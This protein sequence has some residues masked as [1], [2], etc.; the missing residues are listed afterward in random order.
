MK[1]K[2]SQ[3]GISLMFSIFILTFILSIALGG[4]SIVIRQVQITRNIGYSVISFCAAD[5]GV[6]KVL[7]KDRED[8]A[9]IPNG[10]QEV[11]MPLGNGA[12]YT[13]TVTKGGDTIIESKGRY[14]HTSRAIEI[15]Y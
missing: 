13:V 14:K 8:P 9:L 10:Y 2:N 12:E 11:D 7:F 5:S 1:H 3:K 4:A 6:E 15:Q